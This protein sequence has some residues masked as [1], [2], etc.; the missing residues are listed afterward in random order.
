MA[1]VG[2]G[3][4]A[5]EL[6]TILSM[7]QL[8]DSFFPTG[9]YTLSHGL[10]T[11][12]Q[13]AQ[14]ASAGDLEAFIEDYITGANGPADAVAAAASLH[15]ALIEDIQEIVEIDRHLLALKLAHEAAVASTRTG[16]RLLRLARDLS[17]STVLHRYADAVAAGEAPGNFAVGLGVLGAGWGMAPEQVALVELYS[18][19]SGL[20]GASLRLMRIDHAQTQAI[21]R[22]LKPLIAHI[23]AEAAATSYQEMYSF[24]PSIEIAQMRH[25]RA[26]VRLFVS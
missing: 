1:N 23:A 10:E 16:R 26:E 11:L 15:A 5:T 8:G 4:R 20:L 7:L 14:V 25:E 17:P 22:R 21:L 2:E 9:L 6:T 24:A 3:E 19:V 18:F 12:E 13:T